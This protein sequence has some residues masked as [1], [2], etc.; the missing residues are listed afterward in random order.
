MPP[1]CR[2]PRS[3]ASQSMAKSWSGRTEPSFGR[4]VAHMAEARQHGVAA[5]QILVDGLG[6]GGRFDDDDVRH[7]RPSC[8]QPSRSASARQASA[9]PVARQRLHPAGQFQIQQDRLDGGGRATGSAAPDRQP[10]S[11]RPEQIKRPALRR[12][13]PRPFRRSGQAGRFGRGRAAAAGEQRRACAAPGAP[14]VGQ[15][16]E[17]VGRVLDQV[18][19]LADQ[20]VG[21]AAARDRAASR[22]R[23]TAPARPPAPA[24]R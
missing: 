13:L 12:R 22:G 8:G 24:G 18:R 9:T 21:A 19:A 23:R 4:Q 14:D 11:A 17:H 20:V 1:T 16:V 6:L 10:P 5:A 15:V 3:S 7:V 2:S